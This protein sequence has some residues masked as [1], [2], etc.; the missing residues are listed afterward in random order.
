MPRTY[1]HH[2][3]ATGRVVVTSGSYLYSDTTENYAADGGRPFSPLPPGI[4]E[5][6]YEPGVRHALIKGDDVV[7]GGPSPWPEGDAVIGSVAGLVS[8]KNSREAAEVT[9]RLE[10]KL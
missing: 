4:T 6:L 1:F 3:G 5:R 8:S 7:D 9:A 2:H 10:A